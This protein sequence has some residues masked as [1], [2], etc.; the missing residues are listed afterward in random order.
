MSGE[1]LQKERRRL[2][3]C[4]VVDDVV[5]V[6][7]H[8]RLLRHQ[9]NVVDEVGQ[10]RLGRTLMSAL[11]PC[12]R[13]GADLQPAA[14]ERSDEMGQ[15]P[16]K[17]VVSSSSESHTTRGACRRVGWVRATGSGGWS[18]RIPP[19]PRCPPAWAAPR[20]PNGPA[21]S[22]EGE[23]QWAASRRDGEL[24]AQHRH[25]AHL[26][27]A[28]DG[29]GAGQRTGARDRGQNGVAASVGRQDHG[30]QAR[31]DGQQERT[32]DAHHPRSWA[33][34]ALSGNTPATSTGPWPCRCPN[35]DHPL[36]LTPRLLAG[37]DDMRLPTPVPLQLGH[38]GVADPA[39]LDADPVLGPT[40]P[41]AAP[42]V[43][44]SPSTITVSLRAAAAVRAGLVD[45][46]AKR[47]LAS[48][49]PTTSDTAHQADSACGGVGP[50]SSR[51]SCSP[52]C[53]PPLG[54]QLALPYPPA[55]RR[56]AG[57]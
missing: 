40:Q 17:V 52:P 31:S 22:A 56:R 18:C 30:S 1:V 2:V 48:P 35:P 15:E 14:L 32:S 55:R 38:G 23:H 20:R 21:R 24:G 16:T 54:R 13:L 5:V 49:A 3:D 10:N 29:P 11:E 19:A 57:R 28:Q 6:Q 25:S 44:S 34:P 26:P 53:L 46:D 36:K 51:G 33:T 42:P 37:S 45:E 50:L 7:R 27:D 4:R 47:A 39:S 43:A 9:V 12:R 8:D 41:V